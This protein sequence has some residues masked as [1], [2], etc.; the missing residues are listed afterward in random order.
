M[1]GSIAASVLPVA[2][3]LMSRTLPPSRTLGMRR[4]W[5]SVGSLN[6]FSSRSL[7]TGL[8]SVEN[9]FSSDKWEPS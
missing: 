5:G 2:V 9:A 3:G 4:F 6:P 8:Q 7:R 1:T